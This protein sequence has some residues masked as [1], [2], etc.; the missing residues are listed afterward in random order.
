MRRS[1]FHN[2]VPQPGST[3]RFPN[4]VPQPGTPNR[5]HNPVPQ[6]G[7]SACRPARSQCG[8][9]V[10][11]LTWQRGAHVARGAD[12]PV[13]IFSFSKR[14]CEAL[15]QQMVKLDLTDPDE[16]K[17]AFCVFICVLFGL[18]CFVLV[19]VSDCFCYRCL[20]SGI[21]FWRPAPCLVSGRLRRSCCC[22]LHKAQ[23]NED[24]GEKA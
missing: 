22:S 20:G 11:P 16:K 5:F 17:V 10:R 18:S 7:S 19:S 8:I 1:Q 2:S 12:D 24:G 21:L 4:S 6:P 9:A 13:I 3:T 23:R 15:S 14:E